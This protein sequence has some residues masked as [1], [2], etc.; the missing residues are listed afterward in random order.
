MD[1]I[2]SGSWERGTDLGAS[3]CLSCVS[4]P[5]LRTKEEA[6]RTFDIGIY[7]RTPQLESCRQMVDDVL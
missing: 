2:E 1:S 5:E 3:K 4:G 7:N 6:L